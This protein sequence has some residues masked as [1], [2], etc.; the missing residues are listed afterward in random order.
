MTV[1]DKT[2]TLEYDFN[3]IARAEELTGLNLFS[4]FDFTHLSVVKFRAM[5]FASLLKNH[6]KITLDDAGNLVTVHTLPA[7]VVKLV[8][9]WN[10]S[11]PE[12]EEAKGN[13]EAEVEESAQSEN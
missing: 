13:G 4:S 10:G 8:E 6:P 11:R 1:D 3:A 9:A 5:L 2:Y 7:L 12:V